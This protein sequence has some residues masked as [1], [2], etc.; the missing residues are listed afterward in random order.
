MFDPEKERIN[1][2]S[3]L[4]PPAGFELDLAVAATYSLDLPTLISA[5]VP[6]ALGGEMSGVCRDNPVSVFFAIRKIIDKVLIFCDSSAVKLPEK[7]SPFF[8]L[9]DRM[10]YPVFPESGAFHPKMWLLRF[11]DK[12][13]TTLSYRAA[14]LSRNLAFD[15]SWDMCVSFEG[16]SVAE[17][18][19]AN[20]KELGDFLRWLAPK[21]LAGFAAELDS[22][23]FTGKNLDDD[24][25]L[26]IPLYPASKAR[27]KLPA[28]LKG[29]KEKIAEGEKFSRLLAISPFLTPEAV[30]VFTSYFKPDKSDSKMVL[31]SR[32]NELA[33]TFNGFA[34]PEFHGKDG[35]KN[36]EIYHLCD[37]A[38]HGAQS[39]DDEFYLPSDIHAKFYVVQHDFYL[40]SMNL[41]EN[42]KFHN[43]ELMVKIRPRGDAVFF[44][45]IDGLKL[46]DEQSCFET[47]NSHTEVELSGDEQLEDELKNFFRPVAN[48]LNRCKTSVEKG[49]DGRFSVTLASSE[50]PP[51]LPGIRCELRHLGAAEAVPLSEKMRF[52]AIVPEKLSD[53]YALTLSNGTA[54][55]KRMMILKTAADFASE[56]DCAVSA[57]IFDSAGK[58]L[59]FLEFA[60]APDQAVFA[61]RQKTDIFSCAEAGSNRFSAEKS[62]GI[63]EQLL[64]AAAL[65]PDKL[66]DLRKVIGE[67]KNSPVKHDGLDELLQFCGNF[68]DTVKMWK[69]L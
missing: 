15:R 36:F 40:G 19:R 56:R 66:S 68:L 47:F 65:D 51:D 28:P 8:P 13:S 50:P 22:V 25:T 29:G 69:K 41:T 59:A 20:G 2:S 11:K 58:L 57:K 67:L 27:E 54:E 30:K 38:V 55:V 1:Y 35:K 43:T 46:E 17:S 48:Y 53:F 9:L 31:V 61:L 62:A 52:S 45:V 23:R 49:T 12:K 64:R 5:L 32:K 16:T 34:P 44:S 10:I 3:I 60:S 18:E 24:K 14:L 33:K 6:L 7:D 63:Y 4:R 21:K 26:F 39:D 42:G 37:D